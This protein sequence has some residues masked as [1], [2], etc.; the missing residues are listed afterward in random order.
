MPRCICVKKCFV[1]KRLFT[2]GELVEKSDGLPMEYFRVL[3]GTRQSEIDA[4]EEISRIK[5]DESRVPRS[6]V[7]EERRKLVQEKAKNAKEAADK[8]ATKDTKGPGG[9]LE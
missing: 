5:K 9:V 4:K 3:N 8:A 7:Q 6:P 1:R 2:P